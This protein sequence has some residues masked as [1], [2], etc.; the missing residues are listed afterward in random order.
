MTT[1]AEAIAKLAAKKAE[2]IIDPGTGR[3]FL[4]VPEGYS[5]KE[6]SDEYGLKLG[7]PAYISQVVTLQTSESLIGY[8]NWFKKDTILFADIGANAICAAI[9]Y[10]TAGAAANVAHRAA[11][12]LPYSEEWQLWTKISGRLLPQLEFARFIEENAADITAPEAADLLE[13]IR[14]LQAHR[15]VSFIKAVRTSSENENFEY[16]DETKANTKGGVEIPTQFVLNIPVY[17]GESDTEVR[18]FLRWKIDADKGGLELGVQLHRAE[19]VRQAVFKQ[20]VAEVAD[21]TDCG[22]LFG[23]I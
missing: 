11:L 21:K 7:L 18:A 20:I 23:K 17:F 2:I 14:D 22:A 9:D 3:H 10:H 15:K 5:Q 4:V 13:S 1:E 16:S 6:I 12:H 19:H 8:V